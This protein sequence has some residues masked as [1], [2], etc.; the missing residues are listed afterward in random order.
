MLYSDDKTCDFPQNLHQHDAKQKTVTSSFLLLQLLL[1]CF[2]LFLYIWVNHLHELLIFFNV[3]FL[4]RLRKQITFWSATSWTRPL[5][6]RPG[7]LFLCE[8]WMW[9]L[10][11][12][13]TFIKWLFYSACKICN[14]I[15]VEDVIGCF[16][17]I[18]A[19]PL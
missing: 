4:E 13:F 10:T 16:Q 15:A 2:F 19:M 14:K 11:P 18:R 1:R 5:S 9:K 8:M 7:R 12:T 3:F 17:T 6:N